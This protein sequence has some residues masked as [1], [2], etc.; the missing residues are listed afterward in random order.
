[1]TWLRFLSQYGMGGGYQQCMLVIVA[2]V[3]LSASFYGMRIFSTLETTAPTAEQEWMESEVQ[4]ADRIRSMRDEEL[5]TLINRIVVCHHLRN[6]GHCEKC[7]IYPARPCYT[8]VLL[9]WLKQEV[10]E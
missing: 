4:E 6:E 8:D 7:P 2:I 3:V 1:M 9:E 10:S 5:A